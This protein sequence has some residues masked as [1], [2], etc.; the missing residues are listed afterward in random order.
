MPIRIAYM[1][2]SSLILAALLL[3]APT[4][5]ADG[6]GLEQNVLLVFADYEQVRASLAADRGAGIGTVAA[7]ITRRARL[8]QR[9]A[10]GATAQHLGSVRTAASNLARIDASDLVALRRGFSQLSRPLVA[11]MRA[12][13][14]AARGRYLFECP[15]VA[16]YGQWIQT[17]REIENPY[18]GQRML[19]CG[20]PVEPED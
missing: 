20:A 3:D 1:L 8:A 11:L 12:M 9:D 2:F 19:A 7:R 14:T 6:E 13:P 4:A 18:M 17:S 16:G 10:A 15:M 5:R